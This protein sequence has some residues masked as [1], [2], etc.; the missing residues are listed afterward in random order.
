MVVNDTAEDT[1]ASFRL[2]SRRFA[3]IPRIGI[4]F[5]PLTERVGAVDVGEE[6]SHFLSTA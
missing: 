1:V 6:L 4:G 2:Q 3:A 5:R